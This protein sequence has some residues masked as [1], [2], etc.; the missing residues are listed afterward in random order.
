M[1]TTGQC[2]ATLLI[3]IQSTYWGILLYILSLG[4]TK[5]TILCIYPP[6]SP[7]LAFRRCVWV[8]AGIVVCWT[9]T[10]LV[11]AIFYCNPISDFWNLEAALAN[12]CPAKV[13]FLIYTGAFNVATD[14]AILVLPI[15]MLRHVTLPIKKKFG[16]AIVL[17][18]GSL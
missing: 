12:R 15:L 5:T 7:S 6:I 8:L 2:L 11:W 16:V 1:L 10:A 18:T 13:S 14:L 3:Y 17:A 4:F 9:V